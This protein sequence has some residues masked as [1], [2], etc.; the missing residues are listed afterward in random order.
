MRRLSELVRDESGGSLIECM[1][2]LLL[3]GLVT[4]VGVQGFAYVQARS[5]A[6]AAA[7]DGASAAAS[8]GP[9]AGIERA[10]Q[11]LAAGGPVADGLP[12]S[13]DQGATSVTVTVQGR[14]PSL[15]ALA[16]V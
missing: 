15:F 1:L 14:A 11:V 4:G 16:L 10:H 2:A 3:L 9:I 8:A 12:P 13:I 7:Q 6:I 5:V